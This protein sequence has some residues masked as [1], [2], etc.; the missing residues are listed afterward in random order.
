MKRYAISSTA[1]GERIGI[2]DKRRVARE[3]G[4]VLVQDFGHQS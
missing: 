3:E 4:S 1:M 2:G